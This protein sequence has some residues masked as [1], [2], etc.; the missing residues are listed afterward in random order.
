MLY[1]VIGRVKKIRILVC[2]YVL[3]KMFSKYNTP[4]KIK[5]TTKLRDADFIVLYLCKNSLCCSALPM[6]LTC[7]I[8][9]T[10]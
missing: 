4:I 5:W 9:N 1:V 7:I 6:T 10:V 8:T 3:L 2:Y